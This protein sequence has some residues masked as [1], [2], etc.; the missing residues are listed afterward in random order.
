MTS[1]DIPM[2]MS[3]TDALIAHA[4]TQAA[5]SKGAAGTVGYCM[6][7]T[8]AINAAARFPDRIKAAASIYGVRLVTKRDDSPHLTARK[9]KAEIYV[10]A[11]ETDQ[12]APLDEINT[13]AADFKANGVNAEVE[14]YPGVHH[15]FAFPERQAFNKAAAERHW[16][17][18]HALYQRNL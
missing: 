2:I 11:A 6:S 10:G 8:Y 16:E 14:I 9:A 18:L 13:L 1:I 17:R 15:G 3:D 12:F 7:G 4:D 5:A